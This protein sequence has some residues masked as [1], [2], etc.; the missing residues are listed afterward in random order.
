MRL[1]HSE[2]EVI[3]LQH[4][5]HVSPAMGEIRRFKDPVHDYMPFSTEICAIIDTPQFQRLRNIKQL[6][7]SYYV[8]PGASHNRFEHSLGVAYLCQLMAEHLQKAQPELDITRRD[9]KC[10][11]IAGLCHDLGHGPWSH[12]WDGL[13][14]PR[15][16]PNVK[17]RHEDAS[18]M[19]FDA[20]LK[21][22]ELEL[23]ER[24]A[25]FIKALILGDPSKCI[26]QE[27]KRF[28][29]DIVA[30][31]RNGLDVDKF[32]Y[33][34][35]D[36]HAIDVKGNLSLTRLIHSARVID[37]EICYDIKDANQIYEPCYTRFS[38][39]KRIYNHKTARAIEY[40][41]TDALM[42]AEPY[43]NFANDIFNPEKYLHLTDDI[44][45]T[46]E[47]SDNP[48]LNNAKAILHRIHKRDLYKLVDYK[49][50]EWAHYDICRSHFTP[51]GIVEAAKAN[52][53][54]A[55]VQDLQL[56]HVIVDFSKMHYGMQDKNPLDSV[57][58]YSKRH[59]NK[60]QSAQPGDISLLMPAVF[61]EVLV[62]I[63]T[64]DS[65]FHGL[66]QAG[67]NALLTTLPSISDG[68]ASST[69]WDDL[70]LT[71][72]L[73]HTALAP[74]PTKRTFSRVQSAG[75]RL[76]SVSPNNFTAVPADFTGGKRAR[77]GEGRSLSPSPKRKKAD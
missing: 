54:A 8:W 16:L 69:L 22:N 38:L 33:I 15:A 31:K 62:R 75:A 36:T 11:T 25:S 57:K 56:D 6:G 24:D 10:V 2:D 76:F 20:L 28:L 19:M 43:M 12:V 29:F 49:V 73:E 55:A 65:R 39:H 21:D 30:N 35:R 70:R 5:P 14:I 42:A 27:E 47:A 4:R 71:P 37:D 52:N 26:G 45:A 61:G 68:P 44:R 34:G 3:P 63:Y 67:Y 64:R 40:M 23:E 58:F 46:I 41:L 51:K 17:W 9:I 7:T 50:F 60:C 18:D 48:D 13:F 77:K 32:D 53:S 1:M 72:E 66:I 59:P 74:R